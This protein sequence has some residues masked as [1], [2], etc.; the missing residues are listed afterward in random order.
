MAEI[1][2]SNLLD[3]DQILKAIEEGKV[4]RVENAIIQGQL[5]LSHY[6]VQR[7]LSLVNCI[8]RGGLIC[9][10][11]TFAESLSLTNTV[12]EEILDL[13]GCTFTADI[14]ADGMQCKGQAIFRSIRLI[15]QWSSNR[16]LFL[17]AFDFEN[18]TIGGQ[19]YFEECTFEASRPNFAMAVFG[20]YTSFQQARF[21]KGG[22][23]LSTTFQGHL[24]LDG[25][26]SDGEL[27]FT[28]SSVQG[29]LSLS[30]CS[31]TKTV[32]LERVSVGGDLLVI[33]TRFDK[34][35]NFCLEASHLRGLAVIQDC[36]FGG[37]VRFSDTTFGDRFTFGLTEPGDEAQWMVCPRGASLAGSSFLC[38]LNITGVRFGRVANRNEECFSLVGAQLPAGCEFKR[39][40]FNG[41]ASFINA[42][43]GRDFT[44]G[45]IDESL[46][47]QNGDTVFRS[48]VDF[49]SLQVDGIFACYGVEFQGSSNFSE[50]RI[51]G[52]TYIFC[53]C[54]M[55]AA[56]FNRSEFLG[57]FGA[58]S[59]F[60]GLVDF[61]GVQFRK[62]VRFLVIPSLTQECV[63][64]DH[65]D[66]YF[67]KFDHE[68][69]FGGATFNKSLSLRY[70]QFRHSLLF[71][72]KSPES[73]TKFEDSES[74]VTIDLTGCSYG[75]LLFPG[76]NS[77]NP[78]EVV[79]RLEEFIG[80]IDPFDR[81]VFVFLER[82]LRK[83]GRRELAD[84]VRFHWHLCEGGQMKA[85]SARWIWD[86]LLRIF[87]GYGTK[88]RHIVLIVLI[89][90][91]ADAVLA[92]A[93][94]PRVAT[95]IIGTL[96]AIGIALLGDALRRRLLP[97]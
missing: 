6:V 46:E 25:L 47:R 2:E 13:T 79:A 94:V 91:L 61:Q 60:H 4:I 75:A 52:P 32:R 49:T 5:S 93:E 56:E 67:A 77:T 14:V 51:T 73:T 1:A 87:T 18:A 88:I 53:S 50:M 80:R 55:R 85:F 59:D 90:I 40:E 37:D 66:F 41:K 78:E 20:G 96:A 8:V 63:F 26:H 22:D 38:P 39:V 24:F 89:L 97:E 21:N 45:L 12:F 81:A 30:E 92:F 54:F 42:R 76:W 3:W 33:G 43:V 65:V 29:H 95:G 7:A 64:N 44:F 69:N 35:A 84:I 23:F 19:A 58:S 16:A 28:W 48:D 72:L 70:V 71:E 57:V 31:F 15:G 36:E 62:A 82:S 27:Q 9:D 86:R 68:A 11:V 74:K 83:S 17:G 10:H 34:D